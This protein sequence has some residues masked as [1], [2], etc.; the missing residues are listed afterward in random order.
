MHRNQK[1]VTS[2]FILD[3]GRSTSQPD[4]IAR[5]WADYYEN[6]LTPKDNAEF[7][8]KFKGYVDNEVSEITKNSIVDI[9]D[10]FQD[11]ITETEI[12]NILTMLPNSKAPGD[13]GITY[14]H[15][16][17]S[18]ELLAKKLVI[19]YNKIVEL[20]YIPKKFKLRIKIAVSKGG[21]V[22]VSKFDDHRVITLLC[23]FNKIFERIVLKR[24]QYKIRCQPHPLQGAYQ[25][26][27]DA[28]TTSFSI[29]ES[30]KHC[31]QE[32]DKVFA[33]Y[34][35]VSKAFDKVWINGM[36]FK[37]YHNAKIGGKSWR[38]IKSWYSDPEEYV[39]Y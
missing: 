13:D 35:D 20:E 16:R 8:D 19:L 30:I 2:V 14:E 3:N 34:V 39:F 7:D 36:L 33:C 24:L 18:G 10:I 23:T 4:E 25:A 29:D 26:E 27:H 5:L 31:R 22:C 32:N 12:K 28:L 21:K 17:F 38:L 37:L 15:V 11:P 9:D 1:T 6:L